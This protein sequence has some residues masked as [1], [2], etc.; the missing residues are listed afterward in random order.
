MYSQIR[1]EPS[2]P[3]T[4]INHLTIGQTISVNHGWLHEL[5][6][7]LLNSYRSSE[8]WAFV[9]LLYFTEMME[10]ITII[11]ISRFLRKDHIMTFSKKMIVFLKMLIK[12]CFKIPECRLN[13][14]N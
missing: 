1:K 3:V 4:N 14:K 10:F 7:H 9:S 13:F 8:V 12:D 2:P 5:N 6:T 11:D